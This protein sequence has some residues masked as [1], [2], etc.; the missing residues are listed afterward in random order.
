VVTIFSFSA[1]EPD[2]DADGLIGDPDF[3]HP[4]GHAGKRS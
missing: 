2:K 3:R 4:H 1:N